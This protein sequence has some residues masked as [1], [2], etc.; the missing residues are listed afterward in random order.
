MGV[1]VFITGAP[2]RKNEYVSFYSVKETLTG[3]QYRERYPIGATTLTDAQLRDY[4]IKYDNDIYKIGEHTNPLL[5]GVS[6]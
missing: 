4:I 6:R 3:N 5:G 2:L 1:S